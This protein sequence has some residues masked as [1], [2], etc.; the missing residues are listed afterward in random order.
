MRSAGRTC[1]ADL[2]AHVKNALENELR[3]HIVVSRVLDK[4]STGRWVLATAPPVMG[5]EEADWSSIKD[6]YSESS[7]LIDEL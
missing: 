6:G 7:M 2:E 1:L 3:A 5:V 4:G